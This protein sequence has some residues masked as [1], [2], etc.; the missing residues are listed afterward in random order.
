MN[1]KKIKALVLAMLLTITGLFGWSTV[2]YADNQ[3]QEADLSY[4]MTEDALIGYMEMSTRG[5]YLMEGT[6]VINDAGNNTVGAGGTTSAGRFCK[7]AVLAIVE[8]YANGGW[9]RVTSV[10]NEKED[11]LSVTASKYVKVSSGYYYRCRCTH[12]AGTDV[13]Y[14]YTNNLRM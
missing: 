8:R 3:E 10:S 2:G 5:I 13:G 1:V 6:S 14:S 12:Y 9:E 7:V 11:A 4:L